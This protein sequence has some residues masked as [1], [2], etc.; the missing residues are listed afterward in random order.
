V[1]YDRDT[2]IAL[3]FVAMCVG[4]SIYVSLA[5]LNYLRLY[6]ALSDIQQQMP[7]QVDNAS[8]VQ[9]ASVP[10]IAVYVTVSNPTSYSGLGLSHVSVLLYFFA[11]AN[12]NDTIFYNPIALNASQIV[13]AALGPNSADTVNLAVQLTSEQLS[14]LVNFNDTNQGQIMA[15]VFLRVDLSTFLEPVTG[16]VF[17]TRTQDVPLSS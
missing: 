11:D 8:L 3:V 5:A 12:P 9:A 6:P 15:S 4:S 13:G 16:T 14:Q 17:Y 7:Y 10:T 1:R 2:I